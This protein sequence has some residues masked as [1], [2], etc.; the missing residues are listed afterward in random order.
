M[1][2]NF[3]TGWRGAPHNPECDAENDGGGK[4]TADR[5]GRHTRLRLRRLRGR[6][7]RPFLRP[8]VARQLMR[9]PD[10]RHGHPGGRLSRACAT[11]LRTSPGG[12]AAAR[13]SHI[14]ASRSGSAR[15]VAASSRRP[16]RYCAAAGP[17]RRRGDFGRP[18][19][20]GGDANVAARGELELRLHVA[21]GSGLDLPAQILLGILR[22]D[23]R[24]TCG[25]ARAGRRD[26]QAP[27][28]G[29]DASWPQS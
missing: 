12:F 29:S 22:P 18:L 28:E 17:A 16:R 1:R 5:G 6:E 21:A 13:L 9:A 23:R 24:N 4:N 10:L 8:P 11:V 3:S 7:L 19:H 26:R 27:R 20:V 14:C 25:Q 2:V 15:S